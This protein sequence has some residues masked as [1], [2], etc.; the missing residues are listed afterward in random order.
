M[1]EFSGRIELKTGEKVDVAVVRGP[2]LEWAERVE[3]LLVHKTGLWSWQNTAVLQQE[4]GIEVYF[5]LL[6]RD[7]EPFANIMTAEH[8][9]VGHLGHV[10]TKPEER[11]KGAA[12]QLMGWQM[13]HF[14]QRG[15][16]ALFLGTGYDSPPYHIYAAHGFVGMES[17]SGSM[18]YY[19]TSKKAFE[20]EYFAPA[21]TVI[22]TA[23]WSHWPSSSAL[24]LGDWPGVVRCVSLGLLGRQSTEHPFLYLLHAEKEWRNNGGEAQAKALVQTESKAVVGLVRWSWDVLWPQTCLVDLF[25][26]P[27]YWG[28]ADGLLA[29][30]SLP[31]AERFVVYAD[32]L[33]GEKGEILQRAG[34]RQTGCYDQRVATDR[35][36]SKWADVTV[37]EK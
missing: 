5:Y 20:A 36:R 13:D 2:D 1:R 10:F 33:C 18:E 29:S 28:E 30:L 14:R 21:P 16:R 23:E 3:A 19:S 12:S 17:G 9:G 25:C 7:G 37:W 22:E 31:A 27:H 35:V 24:F 15:G 11:R 26:H 32:D 34:F 4:L 8:H 6:C